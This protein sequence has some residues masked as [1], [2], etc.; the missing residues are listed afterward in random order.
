MKTR[1]TTTSTLMAAHPEAA[2][3]PGPHV[4]IK[5]TIEVLHPTKGWKQSSSRIIWADASSLPRVDRRIG[6]TKTTVEI[7]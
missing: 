6:F 3:Y 7:T 5:R 2:R 1:T 4:R